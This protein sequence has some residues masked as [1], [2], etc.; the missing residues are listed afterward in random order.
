MRYKAQ[1]KKR[2]WPKRIII[3]ALSVLILIVGLTIAV[4][5]I[6]FVNLRP[7]DSN[8]HTV[9]TVVIA[10]GSTV[11][12][13]GKQLEDA[14]LIRSAWAFKLYVSS[15][16]ARADL[17]AGTY[18]LNPAQSVAEI[19]ALLTHG[20]V[21]T[22]LVTILPGQTLEQIRTALV[23]YGFPESEVEAA[24]NP[25][26][27]LGNPALVDKPA[28]ASLEGYIYPES[29]QKTGSTTAQDI[30]EQ[31]LAEMEKQLTPDLRASFAQRGLSTYQAIIL[32]SIVEREA[33]N[34]TDREQ[35]AQVYLRR[36][37]IG[38]KLEADPTA[39]YGAQL[40][41]APPSLQYDSP[42]NTYMYAGLPPTPISNV[43]AGSLQAVANPA[44][45]DWLYFVAGDDGI[46]HFSR[47]LAEHEAATDQ[48]CT[49]ACQAQ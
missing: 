4:R 6:Y 26:S 19:V 23:A 1:S 32:A 42:Y 46:T 2:R 10:P 27:H 37:A 49:K 21:T 15:K 44:N 38:M 48:F 30:I 16:E 20:K 5:Q 33:S 11:D 13:I 47:T 17:Q 8:N 35:V 34:Q 28:T 29:F 45:T 25:A 39:F 40:A 41:G 3:F 14:G 9:Q 22:D 12:D 31:S 36:L 43:S 7:V 24:L 18:S